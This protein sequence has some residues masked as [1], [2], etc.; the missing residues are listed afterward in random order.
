MCIAIPVRIISIEGPRATVE[1]GQNTQS[2]LL[3]VDA[4][5]GDWVLLHAGAAIGRVDEEF[6]RQSLQLLTRINR[7]D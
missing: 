4:K 5:V 2:I 6:A 1:I 3:T 7:A